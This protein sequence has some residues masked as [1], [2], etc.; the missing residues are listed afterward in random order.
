[1][2]SSNPI[3]VIQVE[4]V[5]KKFF[6]THRSLGFG[7]DNFFW[8]LKN[9]SFQLNK[10][11]TLGIV[12]A[13]GSGK[14]TLLK[15]LS[16]ATAPS[17]GRIVQ[18]GKLIPIIDTG[19]GFHPDLTGRENIFL[20]G[21]VM[22]GM[23]KSE[24]Q[25][26]LE[27]VI[28][29]SE[30]EE[31]IDEPI[32]NYSNGMYL[33][34]ALSVALFCKLD[35]L[36]LDEVFSVGDSAFML[37]SYNKLSQIIKQETT[38]ILASHSMDDIMRICNKCMWLEK[39]GIKM[40]GDTDKVIASYLASNEHLLNNSMNLA[41]LKLYTK[42]EWLVVDA[43]Q[44]E[45]FRLSTV[46]IRNGEATQS[47]IDYNNPIVIDIEY[48]KLTAD[49]EIGFGLIVTDHH[50]TPLIT[51]S[52]FLDDTTHHH[53]VGLSGRLKST[54]IVPKQLLNLGIYKINLRVLFRETDTSIYIS[55]ILTFKVVADNKIQSALLKAT[56]IKL[57]SSF[58]WEID[59]QLG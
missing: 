37:K 58:L 9:V 1:M 21:K 38:V 24:I 11:D 17:S 16:Q 26:N 22:L 5:S 6:Y 13:N 45:T 55:D 18:H 15:I 53:T 30:L 48:D 7:K 3:S 44:T 46:S 2:S 33:R 49:S 36:L 35:I 56:P 27:T 28:E 19:S 41:S 31:F 54:C 8:A 40:Q 23:S 51:S 32:K 25:E 39:G 4:N 47:Q 20:Y 52:D 34:L 50:G 10:G 57:F 29:F 12:G 42:K 59:K 14:T 43:P